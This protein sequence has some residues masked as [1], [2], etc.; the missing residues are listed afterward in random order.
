MERKPTF[1]GFKY[2]FTRAEMDI[3][4]SSSFSRCQLPGSFSFYPDGSASFRTAPWIIG[5]ELMMLVVTDFLTSNCSDMF[6][7]YK[8]SNGV[9]LL[10]KK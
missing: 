6:D 1:L 4:I 9:E 8:L 5:S 2:Y 10:V 3:L 7:V